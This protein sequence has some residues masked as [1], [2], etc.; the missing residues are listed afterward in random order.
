MIPS[1]KYCIV[2]SASVYNTV[3]PSEKYC[4]VLSA[5]ITILGCVEGEVL[6]SV[7]CQYYNTVI[8]T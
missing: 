1:E 2:L 3:I 5:S 8:S 4:I 6:Y 7:E